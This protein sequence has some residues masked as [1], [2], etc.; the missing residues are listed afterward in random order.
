ML[1][2]I[3]TL[4]LVITIIIIKVQTLTIILQKTKIN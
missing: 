3:L 1:T 2:I 4:K